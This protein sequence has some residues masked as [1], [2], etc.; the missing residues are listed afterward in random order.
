MLEQR[1]IIPIQRT[2]DVVALALEKIGIL[3]FT[4]SGIRVKEK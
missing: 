3:E 1:Q 2:P 4:D